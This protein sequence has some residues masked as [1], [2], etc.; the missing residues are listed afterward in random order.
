LKH[1]FNFFG[2]HEELAIKL[3][4]VARYFILQRGLKT[5]LKRHLA[6]VQVLGNFRR[7]RLIFY[8]AYFMYMLPY[9]SRALSVEQKHQMLT[10]HY[11]FL[12]EKFARPL[13]TELF[14]GGIVCYEEINGPDQYQIILLAVTSHLEFEGSLN[15]VLTLNGKKLYTLSFTFVPGAVFQ[16]ENTWLIFIS[17]IQGAKDEC[18]NIRK[19]IHHFKSNTLPLVLLKVLEALADRL[20]I[21]KFL[22]ISANDQL[23]YKESLNY[24]KFHA[25]YDAFW[26]RVGGVYQNGCYLINLPLTQKAILDIA[27]S[28]R[29]RTLKKRKKLV[30]I[31][32]A[33]VCRSLESS[34]RNA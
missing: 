28:H 33:A 27:Q 24:E 29:N 20:H 5:K 21:D 8:R 1:T 32:D 3:G 34:I 9:I 11:G 25:C 23:S 7:N 19:A 13:L 15:L 2:R 14:N 31:Y 18:E 6:T 10:G 17:A 22:G 30:E 16:Q 12:R 26:T 4:M